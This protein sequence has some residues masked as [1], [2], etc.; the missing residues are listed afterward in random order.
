MT[1]A[2]MLQDGVAG[3]P[4]STQEWDDMKQTTPLISGGIDALRLPASSRPWATP[5]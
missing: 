2:F 3:G 4:Y 5:S 1:I